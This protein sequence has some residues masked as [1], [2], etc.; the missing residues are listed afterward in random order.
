MRVVGGAYGG[1]GRFSEVS[2]RMMYLSYR[3]PNLKSTLDIYDGAGAALKTAEIAD[4]DILQV[5]T[6]NGN[7]ID[8][9]IFGCLCLWYCY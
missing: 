2:G 3:D 6:I 9:L 5:Y 4:Q 1:F 7:V 8:A